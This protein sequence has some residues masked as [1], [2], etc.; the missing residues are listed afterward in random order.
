MS[1]NKKKKLLLILIIFV[2]CFVSA[3]YF[4]LVQGLLIDG[5]VRLYSP[6]LD[7][8]FKEIKTIRTI[9]AAKNYNFPRLEKYYITF[10]AELESVGDSITYKI[11]IKNVGNVD[12]KLTDINFIPELDKKVK[13]VF[14]GLMIGEVLKPD[15]ARYVTLKIEY[16]N[17]LDN[18]KEDFREFKLWLDWKQED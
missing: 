10:F 3:G 17:Q 5:K 11:K 2:C 13:Y 7:V 14:D 9:G 1:I 6:K 18:K 8:Q 16:A 15:E 4:V 12:A